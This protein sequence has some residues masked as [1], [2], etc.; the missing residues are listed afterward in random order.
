MAPAA[1]EHPWVV[2][3][4]R[5]LRERGFEDERLEAEVNRLVGRFP[6]LRDKA[7]TGAIPIGPDGSFTFG[8]PVK[9][10]DQGGLYSG[11]QV[12]KAMGLGVMQ[13]GTPVSWLAGTPD[14]MQELA[15]VIRRD[16]IDAF[17]NLPYDKSTL[18][19]KVTANANKVAASVNKGII[20]L[21]LP[22]TVTILAANPEMWLA[23]AEVID[24]TI[25]QFQ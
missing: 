12:I 3:M 4:R 19:I 14:Q 25:A 15:A 9:P 24:E 6:F 22:E 13:F 7:P 20:E 16:I 8:R 18:P 11:F 21:R 5:K 10:I 2:I 23:L 1:T 17:G